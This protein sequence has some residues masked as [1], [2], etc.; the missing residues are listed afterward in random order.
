M[1][2]EQ[3]TGMTTKRD[4]E[5]KR[6]VRDRDTRRGRER[7]RKDGDREEGIKRKNGINS[8]QAD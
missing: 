2:T 6:G 3:M 4:W 5:R 7:E 1:H 8:W